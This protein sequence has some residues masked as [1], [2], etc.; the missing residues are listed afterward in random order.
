MTP[1]IPPFNLPCRLAFSLKSSNVGKIPPLGMTLKIRPFFGRFL[2]VALL[3]ISASGDAMA[4][5]RPGWQETA[6]QVD[7]TERR[8][9]VTVPSG[10]TRVALEVL[11]GKGRWVRWKTFRVEEGQT[12]LQRRVRPAMANRS[13]R[14]WA[15]MPG[16]LKFP[17]KFYEGKRI[18]ARAPSAGYGENESGPGVALNRAGVSSV[19]NQPVTDGQTSAPVVEADIW[20]ADGT[21]VYFFNQLRGLQVIDLADP[22]DPALLASLRL[23][24]VGQDL[25]LLPSTGSARHAV[26]LARDPADWT[27]TVVHLVRIE[28]GQATLLA[29]RTLEGMLADSRMKGRR[30]FIAAQE[31]GDGAAHSSEK[32]LL[33]DVFVD[34][35]AG[36][37]VA[38]APSAEVE[39]SSS[40]V[41]AGDD[42]MAVAVNDWTDWT[43]SRVTLFS[44]SENGLQKLNTEPF[45]TTGAIKD[46]FKMHV[47]GGVFT[48]I[49]EGWDQPEEGEQAWWGI[50]VARLE[51]F[52]TG[53]ERL[54]ELQ[55]IRGEQLFATRFD[56]DKA[57]AV[58][59]EQVDPLWIIDLTD[60]T[61]PAITGHLE[62]PG[63][64]THLEPLGDLLF[65]IGWDEGRVAAS[66]FDVS[67]PAEPTLAS[68]IFLSEA[69]GGFSESLYDEKALKIL[70]DRNLA[71]VPFTLHDPAEGDSGHRIQLVQIDPAA[72]TLAARG[73]IAHDFEPRRAAMVGSALASISQ[74]Q[75]VTAD[76]SNLDQ[77][78]V[79]A[80]L[81]LAWPVDRLAVVGDRLLQI[82]AGSAWNGHQATLRI[83]SSADPESVELE[84]PLGEG[85]VRDAAV[86]GNRLHVLRTKGG[87]SLPWLRP[88]GGMASA[89]FWPWPGDDESATSVHLDTYDISALPQVTALG[90]ISHDAGEQSL[91]LETGRLLFPSDN[92]AVVLARTQFFR[93]W[94]LARPMPFV[95][96]V[97]RSGVTS[98]GPL[99]V[100]DSPGEEPVERSSEEALALVFDLVASQVRP[101]ALP[102]DRLPALDRAATSEGLVIFGCG[103]RKA[104]DEYFSAPRGHF[105]AVLDVASPE[106][107]SLRSMIPLPGRL[108]AVS[109]LDRAGFLA[110][111]E[112]ANRDGIADGVQV[113]ACDLDNAFLVASLDLKDLHSVDA[114]GRSLYVAVESS[115]RRFT[116]QDNGTLQP[117][118]RIPLEWQPYDIRATADTV[119]ASDGLRIVRT[120]AD[121]FPAVP[122]EWSTATHVDLHAV[123]FAPDGALFSPAGDYGVDVFR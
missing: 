36:A 71:L 96:D 68:R 122:A 81:L 4:S 10:A 17:A 9:T 117:D 1:K 116:L 114:R 66:L 55:I 70:R 13:W 123:E 89:R 78:D 95:L 58:T 105:A 84:F 57:Y 91:P 92:V 87:D 120:T 52:R 42:W 77:P 107:A 98:L 14:A 73:R 37:L 65:S 111:T 51:N 48:A 45:R 39:G 26:L 121:T 67:D 113:S 119:L 85:I 63:W 31:W 59:F 60:P 56:G 29:S 64:S 101:L 21:T 33:Y 41:A 2:L 100:S 7:T 104:F 40:V 16:A 19:T 22:R 97:A 38:G 50:P 20:K 103:E 15:K 108:L 74:R 76:I 69:W 110:W 102:E 118:G 86:R 94:F 80:D 75:I 44:L 61:A 109:D 83:S 88:W 27:A 115:L 32:T 25:Y 5:A 28:N 82:A 53:G 99:S 72:K 49:T 35:S 46:K 3:A 30:L 34:D 106:A 62:V 12:E 90:S 11:N 6:V 8:V 93:W 112:S 18:F 47:R 23:P 24:A 43:T 54:A 79:L